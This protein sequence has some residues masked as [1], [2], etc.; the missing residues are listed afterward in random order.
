M[1]KKKELKNYIITFADDSIPKVKV[2]QM[3]GVSKAKVVDAVTA[4]E[5][6]YDMEVIDNLHYEEL[7]TATVKMTADEAE[8]L[9]SKEGVLEVIE[10]FEMHAIGGMPSTAYEATNGEIKENGIGTMVSPLVDDE[11]A[12]WEDDLLAMELDELINET[13][14]T[15][16]IDIGSVPYPNNNGQATNPSR[17]SIARE[18]LL[19]NIS[20]IGANRAW[21]RSLYGAGIKVAVLDTGIARHRDLILYGGASFVPGTRSYNDVNG[22]GTHCAGVI[23]ARINRTGIIGV[24]PLSRLYAVKV[25]SDSGSGSFSWILS[26]M[27]WALRNKMNVVSMSLG[28]ARPPVQALTRMVRLLNRAGITVVAAAGNSNNSS[29]SFVNTPANCPGV[30]AVGATDRNNRIAHFS[31]RGG[32]WNQVSLC[33]PGVGI[34]STF[35]NNSYR[36]LSG[37]SMA[38]PHVAGAVALI[39][40]RYPTASPAWI[41]RQLMRTARDLGSPGYDTTYGAGLLASNRAV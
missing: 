35:P 20:K 33:A 32:T 38:C 30:V 7:G 14:E 21:H 8:K 5:E 10:D 17:P 1:S 24:A 29:F 31:S 19:W 3:L 2:A 23:G 15:D 28:A 34:V 25:L 37:T 4:M 40:R 13:V 9:R 11:S 16:S 27:A 36:S 41:K 12:A 22:H 39:K 18:H 26:G 6:D